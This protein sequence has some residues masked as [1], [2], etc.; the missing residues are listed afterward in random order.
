MTSEAEHRR[1]WEQSRPV[2]RPSAVDLEGDRRTFGQRVADWLTAL[3]GSWRFLIVQTS[4]L[5]LWVALNTLA[6]IGKWDPYPFILL[7]LA[8]SFQAAYAGPIILMSQ[9]RQVAKDR[10]TAEHDYSV[11]RQAELEIAAVQAR[12]EELAGRQWKALLD[13]QRQQLLL[14]ERIEQFTEAQQAATDPPREAAPVALVGADAITVGT[15]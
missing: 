6:W 12:V 7:N 4:L 8:L 5:A 10:L 13:L 11:D 2:R 3:L 14:L 1:L 15:G 9:N